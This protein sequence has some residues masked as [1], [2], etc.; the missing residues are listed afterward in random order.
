MSQLQKAIEEITYFSEAFPEEA[1]RI[2][3][4]NQEKAIPCLREAV[5][6]AF[7][8]GTD[9]EENYQLHFYAI[10]LLAQFQ[11]REYF[12]RL[13]EFV[14]LPEKELDGL[15]GDCVTSDLSD[16]LYHTY[17]GNI[18]LLE[19]T[20]KNSDVSEYVRAAMLDVMGQLYL[21]GVLREGEWREFLRQ[22]VH[23]G[24]D[25]DYLY[26]AVGCM[27]CRCHFIDMLPEI[28]YMFAHDLLDEMSM[29]RYDS[30][31]DAMFEYRGNE[32]AFCRADF[33]AA[34]T[35]RHWAMFTQQPKNGGTD[36]K[37]SG[38][39]SHKTQREWDKPA[40]K[41]KIGRNDPCPC[42]SGKKYK[43][44][45]LNKPAD[46]MDLI[47]SWEERSKWLKSYP[48]TGQERIEGRIYLADYFDAGSIEI[49]KI[50]YLALRKRQGFI[51][52]RNLSAEENR[53]REYLYLA[54]QKCAARM[55]EEQ[56][57]SFAEYDEKYS[58]HYRCGE[59]LNTLR[60]L[61]QK[62]HDAAKQEEVARFI[63]EKGR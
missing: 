63:S 39:I 37:E 34:D 56:I 46:A 32:K 21:D 31:V 20:I 9:L 18:E 53:T 45:C 57:P 41:V 36:K 7:R 51:W 30:Y 29:G 58:I 19:K 12:P 15:I 42:G 61:L 59:W 35:L 52:N 47:E 60:G 44:C 3:T 50:L 55:E 49:D 48:Y 11:D 1:F 27:L 22:S 10:Y 6:Y 17:N 25:Y 26:D 16:I 43:F 62:N 33:N 24:R 4:E 23:D 28:R 54:Y 40:G 13:V 8:K 2:I 14:S 5:E 38:K